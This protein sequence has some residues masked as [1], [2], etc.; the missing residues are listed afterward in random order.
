MAKSSDIRKIFENYSKELSNQKKE[1]FQQITEW[2]NR[3]VHEIDVHVADQKK[4]LDGEYTNQKQ[5]LERRCQQFKEEA[6]THEKQK[7]NEK[8]RLLV[9]Q[10]KELQYKLDNLEFP[11]RQIR[12]VQVITKDRG[13]QKNRNEGSV[14]E[15]EYKQ[16][17]NRSTE[18]NDNSTRN[19]ASASS[20]SQKP[21]S[22]N[23]R[24][25]R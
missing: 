3:R 18:D 5:H 14:N 16:S 9:Q 17:H 13:T 11:M 21:T 24:Q 7:D 25:T 8:V 20:F 12:F 1:M 2:R 22:T 10:C 6:V 23:A 19:T 15:T 4:L